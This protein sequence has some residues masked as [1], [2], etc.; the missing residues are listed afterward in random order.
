VKSNSNQKPYFS[1]AEVAKILGIS[2]VAVFKKIQSGKL[3]AQ[4]IGRNY[5]IAKSDLDAFLGTSVSHEQQE[6]IK[7]VV[8][9]AVKEYGVAFRRLGKEE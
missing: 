9:K 6:E 1:T 2:S 8:K 5:I 4:K 7:K 3:I